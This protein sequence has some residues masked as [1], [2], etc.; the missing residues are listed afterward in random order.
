MAATKIYVCEQQKGSKYLLKAV[1]TVQLPKPLLG[2]ASS[3]FRASFV[4][5][6]GLLIL[7]LPGED[8][9]ERR[10]L[11]LINLQKGTDQ[12]SH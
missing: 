7:P 12:S 1:A 2:F 9:E 10:M 6:T 8:S 11:H 5:G 4:H 3:F